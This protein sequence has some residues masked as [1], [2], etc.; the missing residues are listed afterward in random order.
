MTREELCTTDV[1]EKIKFT[2]ELFL[3]M[4]DK[5]R[6]DVIRERNYNFRFCDWNGLGI[7]VVMCSNRF[8][9]FDEAGDADDC[10]VFSIEEVD[11]NHP[12]W[13][14]STALRDDCFS[15][16]GTE[17]GIILEVGDHETDYGKRSICCYGSFDSG[18]N[19]REDIEE[20][21]TEEYFFQQM[22][23]QNII[24][25]EQFQKELD[26][27]YNS[28]VRFPIARNH[29]I[30]INCLDKFDVETLKGFKII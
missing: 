10:A 22:T 13:Y 14:N 20:K 1:L 5:Y 28:L 9:I 21:Y 23:V 26:W 12:G 15:I 16:S 6:Q 30:S 24:P 18:Y 11:L 2:Y 19:D 7:D 3:E 4:Q 8:L 17:S 29:I 25:F 27:Y